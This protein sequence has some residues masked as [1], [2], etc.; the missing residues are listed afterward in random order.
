ME[1]LQTSGN[2]LPTQHL[3]PLTRQRHQNKPRKNKKDSDEES[4]ESDQELDFETNIFD[5]AMSEQH[6]FNKAPDD[7]NDKNQASTIMETPEII[8]IENET[9][10][11]EYDQTVK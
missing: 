7:S 6:H 5:T 8:D 9:P 2:T 4:G 1:E 3:D 11:A 10:S